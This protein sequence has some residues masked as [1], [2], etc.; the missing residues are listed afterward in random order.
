MGWLDLGL[1]CLSGLFVGIA[2]SVALVPQPPARRLT[3][4]R[5]CLLLLLG[6]RRDDYA[7]GL[8]IDTFSSLLDDGPA[9]A[10]AVAEQLCCPRGPSG[11]P[12]GKLLEAV[13]AE[14]VR[15]ARALY[16]QEKLRQQ[17]K[18]QRIE[19]LCD[20][21]AATAQRCIDEFDLFR[22]DGARIS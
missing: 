12:A 21:V 11:G 13:A 2:D 16:L 1:R 15:R 3:A 7:V 9:L 18:K 20:G 17:K 8:V 14:A 10:A 4:T 22:V 19:R 5:V 6:L